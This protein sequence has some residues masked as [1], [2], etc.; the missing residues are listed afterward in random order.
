[1][2]DS[3]GYTEQDLETLLYSKGCQDRKGIYNVFKFRIDKR[4]GKVLIIRYR[5]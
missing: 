3:L 4:E 5:P 2:R 1:M